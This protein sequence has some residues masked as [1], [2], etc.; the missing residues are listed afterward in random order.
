MEYIDIWHDITGNDPNWF[1]SRIRITNLEN[2][3]HY[4]FICNDW[5]AI[6]Q[7]NGDIQRVI[8]VATQEELKSFENIFLARTTQDIC[9]G[10]IW[11]SILTRPL[12][13]NFTCVQRIS[14]CLSF[15]LSTMLCNAMFYRVKETTV[16]GNI[17]F[18]I[19]IVRMCVCVCVCMRAPVHVCVHVRVC[20]CVHVCVHVCVCG[21]VHPCMFVCMYACVGACM[22]VCMYARVGAC[23]RACLCTYTRV[24]ACVRTCLCACMRVWVHTHYTLYCAC[25]RVRAKYV[26]PYEITYNGGVGILNY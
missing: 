25:A 8:P 16:T 5:L 6:D 22:F 11:F 18:V 4:I 15:L 2:N 9:D 10:H 21:C 19:Y 13:S 20:G 17:P 12:R 26:I 3:E 1:L 23:V 7:S 14:C 24:C